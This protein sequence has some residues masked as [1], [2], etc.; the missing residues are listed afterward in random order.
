MV[1]DLLVFYKARLTFNAII[2]N[3]NNYL[4]NTLTFSGSIAAF[5]VLI[6][7][8]FTEKNWLVY[9][10]IFLLSITMLIRAY[11]ED[12]LVKRS[13]KKLYTSRFKYKRKKIRKIQY[14]RLSKKL[15]GLSYNDL[16]LLQEQITKN[17]IASKNLFLRF[18]SISGVLIIPLW[19][20]ILD[21]LKDY[22]QSNNNSLKFIILAIVFFTIVISSVMIA[23]FI[24]LRINSFSKYANWMK[25]N[26]IITNYRLQQSI[27]K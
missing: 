11:Y 9:L 4:S 15:A 14:K 8:F 22:L 20:M 26:S 16:N 17:A 27:K 24:D 7:S 18:L 5:F 2:K 25:L 1:E 10:S 23:G 3:S 12:M 19:I 6:F 21:F 13:K